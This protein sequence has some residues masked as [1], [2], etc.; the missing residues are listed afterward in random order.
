[1]NVRRV[2][3]AVALVLTLVASAPSAQAGFEDPMPGP[4][5][6]PASTGSFD[7]GDMFDAMVLGME[8]ATVAS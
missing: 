3:V 7:G 2:S 6:H 1:V 4:A 8:L 5:G